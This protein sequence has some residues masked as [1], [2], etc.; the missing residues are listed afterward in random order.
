MLVFRI[1]LMKRRFAMHLLTEKRVDL[2]QKRSVPFC[3]VVSGFLVL[4]LGS[5]DRRSE[6]PRR[7]FP[8]F[9][10]FVTARGDRRADRFM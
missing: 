9:V 2:S 7:L 3:F 6:D 5:W 1:F 8:S 4:Q 10:D